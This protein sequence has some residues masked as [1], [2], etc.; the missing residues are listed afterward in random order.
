MKQHYRLTIWSLFFLITSSGSAPCPEK[1]D[2]S[3]R[4][5]DNGRICHRKFKNHIRISGEN[6]GDTDE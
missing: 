2:H 3:D 4:L 6:H 5:S 1:N